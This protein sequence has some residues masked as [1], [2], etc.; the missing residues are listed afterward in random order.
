MTFCHSLPCGVL[1]SIPQRKVSKTAVSVHGAIQVH[2]SIPQRK[3]SKRAARGALLYRGRVSIPQRKVS[4]PRG[5]IPVRQP[6]SEFPSLKGRFQSW[7]NPASGNLTVN[8]SIPQRKVSKD[9]APCF[10]LAIPLVSIPQRKVSKDL[11]GNECGRGPLFPSLKGRFQRGD[12]NRR[13]SNGRGVS[14][15]QRKVSKCASSTGTCP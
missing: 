1:V 3:V 4:K 10:L 12:G 5:G 2:V 8:V 14:I 15:P 13:P 11:Q 9:S 7:I 6:G